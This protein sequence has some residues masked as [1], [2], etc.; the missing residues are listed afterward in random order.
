MTGSGRLPK[1]AT[2]NPEGPVCVQKLPV[3]RFE[4]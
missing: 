1:F 4:V 3:E 2:I